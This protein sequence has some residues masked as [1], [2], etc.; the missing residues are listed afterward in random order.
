MAAA[1]RVLFEYPSMVYAC[2][3]PFVVGGG[4]IIVP[5]FGKTHH[6][7]DPATDAFVVVEAGTMHSFPCRKSAAV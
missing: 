6:H 5:S 3:I 1:C 7:G 4:S 2:F